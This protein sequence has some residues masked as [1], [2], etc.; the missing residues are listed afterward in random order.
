MAVKRKTNIKI[1]RK[2]EDKVAITKQVK[3]TDN[4]KFLESQRLTASPHTPQNFSVDAVRNTEIDISWDDLIAPY[5]YDSFTVRVQNN[6]VGGI[7]QEITGIA[8]TSITVTNV[9]PGDD[10]ELWVVS[11]RNGVESPDSNHDFGTPNVLSYY[12]N[13]PY[14]KQFTITGANGA[15]TDFQVPVFVGASATATGYDFHVDGDSAAFPSGKN[16]SGDLRF[17]N[18][19]EDTQYPFWVEQVT[20]AGSSAVAKIWVKVGAN[21]DTDKSLYCYYGY[22]NASNVS[23]GDATF[24]FFDDF[25]GTSLDTNKWQPN[26]NVSISNSEL[27]VTDTAINS[28]NT[29]DQPIDILTRQKWDGVTQFGIAIV[30]NSDPQFTVFS[31]NDNGAYIRT[32]SAAQGQHQ[33]SKIFSTYLNNGDYYYL[34]LQPKLDTDTNIN[35]YVYDAN[36][37]LKVQFLTFSK[38]SIDATPGNIQ[39]NAG[40]NPVGGN[41]YTDWIIVKKWNSTAP[42]FS[43]SGAEIIR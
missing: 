8:T 30:K 24:V 29:Y 20:G 25:E 34:L 13:W 35:G 4:I 39:I 36:Y 23:D 17:G 21:L 19:A 6:T 28:V 31:Y 33:T 37:N 9:T 11:V 18:L 10:Y 43:S 16:D 42:S 14:K 2:I 38:F 26:A 40:Y 41:A 5:T 1:S 7:E 15:G 27:D 22:A 32:K 3:L 12:A